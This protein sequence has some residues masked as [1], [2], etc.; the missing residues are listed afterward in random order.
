MAFCFS[1]STMPSMCQ[2]K[3]W[4]QFREESQKNLRIL[5]YFANLRDG[6]GYCLNLAIPEKKFLEIWQALVHFFLPNFMI[7]RPMKF[8]SNSVFLGLHFIHYVFGHN[9]VEIISIS[10]FNSSIVFVLFQLCQS[11]FFQ[12]FISPIFYGFQLS[13]TLFLLD[14]HFFVSN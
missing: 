1:S 14:L 8:Y 7:N 6:T 12:S 13:H 4:L 9:L 11:F 2:A 3:F 5:L 10:A